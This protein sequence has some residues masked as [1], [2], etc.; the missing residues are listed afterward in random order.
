MSLD[1]RLDTVTCDT[2]SRQDGTSVKSAPY[3]KHELEKYGVSQLETLANSFNWMER[4]LL[5]F[6][7]YPKA[8]A[9]AQLS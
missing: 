4:G 7:S 6:M 8:Q 5:G 1:P 2:P 3:V 9:Y